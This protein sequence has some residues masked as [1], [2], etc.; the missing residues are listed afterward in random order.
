M[1]EINI[2]VEPEEKIINITPANE[3]KIEVKEDVVNINKDTTEFNLNF[4]GN[5]VQISSNK[6]DKLID[7]DL[8]DQHPIEAITNLKEL[9]ERADTFVFEQSIA[10][11]TWEIEH[12]LNKFPSVTI[13]DSAG[14]AYYAAVQYESKNKIIVTMNGATTGKAYLN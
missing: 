2:N 1:D 5:V 8:P 10:S 13:V 4:E 12:N 3:V 14:T 9:L 11:D 6:H 7:R